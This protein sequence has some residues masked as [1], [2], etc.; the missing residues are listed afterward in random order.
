MFGNFQFGV[1]NTAHFR[2][3]FYQRSP[4]FRCAVPGEKDPVLGSSRFFP[5]HG[6]L[7]IES[8]G[9]W[10]NVRNASWIAICFY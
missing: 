7:M 6:L 10:E 2:G 8:H 1:W 5:G 9:K 4:F 3:C